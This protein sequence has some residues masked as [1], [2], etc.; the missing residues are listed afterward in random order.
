LQL[1]FYRRADDNRV[2]T[3]LASGTVAKSFPAWRRMNGRVT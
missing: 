1:D 3:G 2:L